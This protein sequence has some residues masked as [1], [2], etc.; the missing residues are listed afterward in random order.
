MATR[1]LIDKIEALPPEKRAEVEEFVEGLG[2]SRVVRHGAGLRELIRQIHADRVQLYREHGLF[3]TVP[4]IREF[5]ET[6]R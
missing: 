6:G 4:L 3:D 5:R 2:T 1:N